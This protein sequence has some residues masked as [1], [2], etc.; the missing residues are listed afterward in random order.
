MKKRNHG[1]MPQFFI[2]DNHEPIFSREQGEMVREI[3]E[4][5]RSQM[6]MDDSGK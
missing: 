5:R 2:K 6:D 1:E 3:L 4:Y